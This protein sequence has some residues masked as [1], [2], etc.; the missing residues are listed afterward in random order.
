MD[1]IHLRSVV[2]RIKM[3]SDDNTFRLDAQCEACVQ[4]SLDALQSSLLNREG[5]LHPPS[6][7]IGITLLEVGRTCYGSNHVRAWCIETRT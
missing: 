2:D 4:T 6:R 5:P 3:I 7:R 1:W